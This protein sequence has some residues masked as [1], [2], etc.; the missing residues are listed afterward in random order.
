MNALIKRHLSLW[1]S[2]R[3]L[4]AWVQMWMAGVL[5]PVNLASL[6]LLH[7]SSAQWIALCAVTVTGSNMLLMYKYAGFSRLLAVPHL[8]IWGPLQVVLPIYLAQQ[9]TPLPTGELLYIGLVLAVNGISLF[10]DLLD[11]WRWLQG[12]RELF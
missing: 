6:F 1:H 10:F 5:L 11:T 7:Y 12:E 9:T 2:F 8:L 3:R 4:P